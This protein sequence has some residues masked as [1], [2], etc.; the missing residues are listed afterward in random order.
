[1]ER[2]VY[3]YAFYLLG[4]EDDA[5]DVKQET[6]LR[7]Y[8]R[9]AGFRGDAVLLTWLLKICVNMC[10]DRLRSRERR[11]LPFDASLRQLPLDD[12]GIDP[13]EAAE[14][15]ETVRTI[16]RAIGGMPEP[17]REMIV[18]HEIEGLDCG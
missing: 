12:S 3:R 16:L 8:H 6:F 4:H 10:R 1:Y 13:A 18:L 5:A 7:A 2:P 9:I 14:R 17:L 11:H 15:A